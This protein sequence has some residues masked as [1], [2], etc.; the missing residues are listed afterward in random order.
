MT[1]RIVLSTLLLLPLAL[2]AC[3]V[4][5]TNGGLGTSPS[6]PVAD[7]DP[8]TVETLPLVAPRPCGLWISYT[9]A[10]AEVRYFAHPSRP[11]MQQNLEPGGLSCI[12]LLRAQ[13]AIEASWGGVAVVHY[14]TSPVA[15]AYMVPEHV[16][17]PQMQRAGIDLW[18]LFVD[19]GGQALQA[20]LALLALAGAWVLRHVTLSAR[21]RSL[22]EELGAHSKDV[23]QEV[24]QTYVEAIKAGRADGQLTDAEKNR[25]RDMAIAKLRERLS[26][27]KLLQ[28][29]GGW[30]ARLLG[31]TSF[32]NK[33]ES[34]LGGAV[35][36]AV[37]EAK[38]GGKAAGLSTSG[39]NV[40][41]PIIGKLPLQ[42]PP[43][44]R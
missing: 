7:D 16:S 41:D 24:F 34:W 35:E 3:A 18:G 9:Y 26:W 14:V 40:P 44:P 8:V 20:A 29:G 11:D 37:A 12:D 39:T 28:L 32:E 15:P 23:V 21:W 30:L 27:S 2:G 43:S 33:V 13:T 6:G 10:D 25:A 5:T 31:G 38:R 1:A 19:R 22:L 4:D 17:P 36:T 42:A